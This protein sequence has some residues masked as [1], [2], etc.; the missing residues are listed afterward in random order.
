MT[1]KVFKQII[2]ILQTSKIEHVC[3]ET[4]DTYSVPNLLVK[5]TKDPETDEMIQPVPLLI[6]SHDRLSKTTSIFIRGWMAYSFT[7][8]QP[9]V[10]G[11]SKKS[12]TSEETTESYIQKIL[13]ICNE[14]KDNSYAKQ[15]RKIQKMLHGNKIRRK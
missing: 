8:K 14:R 6:I 11:F 13:H 12:E 2:D 10:T 4:N 9:V 3:N 15:L 7:Q 1:P 5:P